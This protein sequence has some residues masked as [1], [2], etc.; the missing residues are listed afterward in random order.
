M[1]IPIPEK[2]ENKIEDKKILKE[3]VN[4]INFNDNTSEVDER[5]IFKFLDDEGVNY[6]DHRMLSGLLWVIYDE[7]KKEKIENFFKAHNYNYSLE[8]RGVILTS[9]KAAWRLKNL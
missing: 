7:E 8:K 4:K 2:I 5:D 3:D 6:I 9:G 1:N